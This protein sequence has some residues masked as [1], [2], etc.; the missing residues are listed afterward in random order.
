MAISLKREDIYVFDIEADALLEDATKIHCLSIGRVNKKG[1]FKIK[2]FT[3]YE[4]MT[5]F[6]LDEHITKIGHNIIRYDC[7]VVD[8]ILG[9]K[10]PMHNVIDT[11]PLSWVLFPHLLVH[12][13]EEWGNRLDVH[14]IEITSWTDQSIEDYILRCETDIRINQL[15]WEEEYEYLKLLYKSNEDLIRFIEYSNFK[16]ICVREQEEIGIKFD[17]ERC[18]RVMLKLESEINPKIE[19]LTSIMPKIE[20]MGVKSPPKDIYKKDGS[21]SKRYLDFIQFKKDYNVPDEYEG[22]IEY[23]KGYK[24]PSAGSSKQ[25]KD[26]LFSLGWEPITFALSAD[27]SREVPQIYTKDKKVCPSI[28]RLYDKVPELHLLDSLGV[29]KHKHSLLKGFLSEAKEAEDGTLRLY[30][31]IS[32]YTNTMRL[33]H[34]KPLVNMPKISLPYGA[35][36]RGCLIADEGKMLMGSDL[37]SIESVTRNHYLMPYDPEYVKDL[38]NPMY[39]SHIDLGIR[40][41]FFSEEDG[42]LY[43][44]IDK[45]VIKN[46]TQEQKDI[47]NKVKPLRNKSKTTNYGVTYGQGVNGLAKTLGIPKS[48]AKVLIDSYWER[49]WAIRAF[50]DSC[51][52]KNVGS[53]MWILNPVSR[54][55][56][57]LRSDKDR[58]ATVNSSTAVYVFDTWVKHIKNFGAKVQYQCHD[59]HVFSVK[60]DKTE[61][62]K[63]MLIEAIRLTNEELQLEV[64]VSMGT[65]AGNNYGEIH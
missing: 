52:V 4:D 10:T 34:K 30:G 6:F 64:T 14:K 51:E 63:E 47:F 39:D 49:N 13:L 44:D 12:G 5:E 16:S 24:E 15:L 53:Q 37:S 25:L 54:F 57:T 45:G 60:K 59:E 20:V 56:Y 61:L 35:D 65:A 1:E 18:E 11:L 17:K 32:G 62:A 33:I 28:E 2:T 3:D 48:E 42:K 50:A 7:C 19:T 21:Y 9:I 55:W 46:P 58:F 22:D 27:K 29:L 43:I 23:V 31:S 8:K 26:F 41:N 36:I 40:A 38:D